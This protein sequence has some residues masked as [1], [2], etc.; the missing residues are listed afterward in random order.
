M[1]APT[2]H[3]FTLIPFGAILLKAP[4]HLTK[5]L[6]DILQITDTDYMKD[7]PEYTEVVMN[8]NSGASK[9]GGLFIENI[10]C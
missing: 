5:I 8:N 10:I 1:K 3:C 6:A 7:V 9:G 4:T 2:H